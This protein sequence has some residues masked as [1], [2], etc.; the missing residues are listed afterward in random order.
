VQDYEDFSY[1]FWQYDRKSWFF[2]LN[3]L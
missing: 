1:Q 2:K 3:L